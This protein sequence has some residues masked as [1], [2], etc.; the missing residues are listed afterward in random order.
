MGPYKPLR[1][2]V[3]EFIPYYMEISWKFRPDRTYKT[4]LDLMMLGKSPQPPG[5]QREPKPTSDIP[6][7][8]HGCLIGILITVYYN[9]HI[10]WQKHNSPIQKTAG[11]SSISPSDFFSTYG[12]RL[13]WAAN[14]L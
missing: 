2:W 1:T 10:T 12:K 5:E 9:S 11:S 3:D 4:I 8:L 7:I 13:F 6:F 14:R